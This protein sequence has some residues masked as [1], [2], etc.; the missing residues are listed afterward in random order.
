MAQEVLETASNPPRGG[1]SALDQVGHQSFLRDLV[2]TGCTSVAVTVALLFITRWLAEG[3][4]PDNF[5]AYALSRR[6]LSVVAEFSTIPLGIGITR[7]LALAE[8][9]RSRYTIVT[10]GL[11]VV[12]GIGL[13]LFLVGASLRRVLALWLFGD[14]AQAPVLLA[15]LVLFGCY[16]FYSLLY[17]TYRGLSRMDR[18]NVWQAFVGAFGP[19]AVA[20]HARAIGSVTP[21]L[22]LMSLP[23]GCALAPLLRSVLV[24]LRRYGALEVRPTLR[25]L[26]QYSLPRTLN[27]VAL[28][29]LFGAGPLFAPRAGALRQA[30]YLVVGQSLVG[31]A[32]VGTE[33]FGVVMLPRIA[34]MAAGREDALLR[35]GVLNLITLVVDVG[36]FLV[37]HSILWADHIVRVLLGPGFEE[38]VP[39]VRGMLP[40]IVPWLA[41]GMLR[42]VNDALTIRAVNT[43]NL[44]VGAV[45]TLV[46]S[47]GALYWGV[48]VVG[49][50]VA[51]AAGCYALGAL[52]VRYV[53]LRCEIRFVQLAPARV[54]GVNLA[55]LGASLVGRQVLLSVVATPLLLLGIACLELL[56][57]GVYMVILRRLQVGWVEEAERQ[58]L[59][60][61]RD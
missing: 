32:Q 38:A 49:L 6:L 7:S 35:R 37:L 40:A 8:D 29:C 45:T 36:A 23:Y 44:S 31:I 4:G 14:A 60:V 61:V 46:L 10:A 12:S 30:G 28:G 54:V 27:G 33:A 21:I 19:L 58:L 9:E 24:G 18:V 55:L 26:A 11:L 16:A 5:G 42:S 2:V 13:S 52:T 53:A 25:H 43:I 1:I 51:F 34:R 57:F 20:W 41:Y 3:L 56:V 39:V 47:L 59:R 50:A 17:N 15:A 48:G 22:L